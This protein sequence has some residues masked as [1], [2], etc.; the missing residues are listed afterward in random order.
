MM[1]GSSYRALWTTP[2]E[3]EEL[4]LATEA[5]GLSIV[6]RVGGQQTLGLALAGQNGRSYTFRGLDKDPSNILPDDLQDTFVEELVQ[7]QMSAQHPAGALVADEISKAV[8]V[9]TVPI[10]LVVMRD[11][12][13]LGELRSTFGG[14]LGTFAE[15]PTAEDARHPGFEGAVE[16]LDHMALYAKLAESPDERVAGREFLRARLFDLLVSD[17]DRHRKQWRWAKRSGDSLWHSI[18]EDRD[19]AFARYEGVLV[20]AVAGYVP[21]L[22]T[23]GPKYDR[24]LGLTYWPR[25]GPLG[26]PGSR[27]DWRGRPR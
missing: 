20:R 4:D 2:V 22:R 15:Y 9:P 26:C 23:F 6:R 18:P 3:V 27:E 1:L 17:F 12:P 5:G 24:I 14:L 16:I 19:Q 21:Q 10:R 11:D 8:G 25:A 7:D 13:A